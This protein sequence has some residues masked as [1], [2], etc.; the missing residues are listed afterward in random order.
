LSSTATRNGFSC[1][2][3][4]VVDQSW[5]AA[6]ESLLQALRA[7][8]A[9]FVPVVEACF[10]TVAFTGQSHFVVGGTSSVSAAG[11]SF[12]ILPGGA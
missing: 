10:F 12:P 6:A 5:L 4:I 2:R 9:Y 8:A 11:L 1:P 3:V 7:S